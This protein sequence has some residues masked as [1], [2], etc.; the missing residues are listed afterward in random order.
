MSF[1]E[2][3]SLNITYKT[4][5]YTLSIPPSETWA[6]LQERLYGFTSVP[7]AFQKLLYKGKKPAVDH[8]DTIQEAGLKDGAKV[9]LLG[10]TEEEVGSLKA[11]E[12]EKKRREEIMK[13][14]AAKGPTKVRN[15]T[16]ATMNNFR[17]HKLEPLPHLP[18]PATALAVLKQLSEDPAIAHVMRAHQYSI[19]LLTELAPHEHPELL[20]LNQ[21]RGE[22]IKLRL[23]TDAYDGFRSYKE[24]R[25]VLCHELTH[26][27]WGDHDDNFKSLNSQLNREVA[28]FE[29][30]ALEG[31]HTLGG[32]SGMYEV[33][34]DAHGLISGSY[35]L[36]GGSTTTP[37]SSEE[38]RRRVL[39]AAA[40]RLRREEEEIEGMCGSAGPQATSSAK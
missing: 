28:E 17:F 38:R 19:G 1:S 35:V 40:A 10:S 7:P 14:R 29:R 34:A 31:S 11:A 33:E 13:Q 22:I 26:C 24:I 39:E 23:R 32:G 4:K 25:R 36:G 2:P 20:G 30:A 12:A 5:H 15:T 3:I 27:V 16:S 8:D 18:N 6:A 9:M 21:N 37:D